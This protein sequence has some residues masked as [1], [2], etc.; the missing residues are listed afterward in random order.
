MLRLV[1]TIAALVATVK[2]LTID[3]PH[4][5]GI[6]LDLT[7]I[8]AQWSEAEWRVDLQSMRDVGLTFLVVHHTASGV[9]DASD[10]CPLG[11]YASYFPTSMACFHQTGSNATGGAVGTIIRAAAAVGLRV[12]LGLAIQ[13]HLTEPDGQNP[14][15][16]NATVL[17]AFRELQ[18]G[19]ARALWTAFGSSNVISGFYTVI[20]QPQNYASFL[21]HWMPMARDYLQ[22]LAHY[23]KRE[24]PPRRSDD[25]EGLLVWSSPDAV[26]NWSRYPRQDMLGPQL[27]ADLW[28]QAF[29]VAPD[30]DLTALQ[31]SLGAAGNSLENASNFL[32]N[33][34][35]AAARQGRRQ[36]SNIELFQTLP[37]DCRWAAHKPCTGRAPAP[38][39]RVLEQIASAARA[40]NASAA[41]AGQVT[42]AWEWTSCLSPNGGDAH[43]R[44]GNVTNLTRANWR[45]YKAY[46]AD[47]AADAVLVIAL[48]AHATD[49][50]AYA[51]ARL[52]D[53]LR[54]QLNASLPIVLPAAAAGRAH[55]AVGSEAALALLPSI[56]HNL[57]SLGEEGFVVQTDP[58]ARS[59]AVSGSVGAPRGAL[60]AVHRLLERAGFDFL[61]FD[62]TNVPPRD[63][64]LWSGSLA[65]REMPALAWRHTN[66]ANIELQ[67]HVNFSI[68]LN[69]NN[70]GG[71]KAYTSQDVRKP[72]G[73]VRTADPPGFVHT[74]SVLV[75]PASYQATHPEWFASTATDPKR[76]A[77]GHQ[78]C[79]GNRS[80]LEFVARAAVDH[81]SQQP[82]ANAIS[83]SQND[84]TGTD[85]FTDPCNRS[86]DLAIWREEGAWSG[87][88][89]RGV[90]FVADQVAAAF[91][92]RDVVVTTL[93]YRYTRAPPRTTRPRPNVRVVLAP[94]ECSWGTPLA[95]KRTDS[96][97]A[98]AAEATQTSNI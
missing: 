86:A 73:G 40:L 31:D 48:G 2:S 97:A 67:A 65:L 92:G 46:L 53:L 89:L 51:A 37:R 59:V 57:S 42:V 55:V 66:N 36:W 27:Y 41:G 90:N 6:F 45:A 88:L 98:F 84:G 76:P 61:T 77:H 28:E 15:Y 69:N 5:H 39:E 38:M 52:Q 22:P 20:E 80:L 94:I 54:L 14:L 64:P 25:G 56:S 72:G 81:L 63:A 44:G 11:R 21:P 60:Y 9:S 79:W 47:G 62:V 78:L 34:S 75:P 7:E 95:R 58:A 96:N 10:L 13:K 82:D 12:H 43:D 16:A 83:I 33:L 4:L 29:L 70:A 1:A 24:L 49:G 50:E 30:F 85:G 68:A 87:P 19:V 71:T 18:S 26:G 3:K 17:Q 8:T 74:S 91:P 23:I 32:G 93:A 35:L